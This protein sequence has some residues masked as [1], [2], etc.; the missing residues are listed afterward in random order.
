MGGASTISPESNNGGRRQ[1]RG[2]RATSITQIL[3]ISRK[4]CVLGK[5]SESTGGD[6]GMNASIAVL[7]SELAGLRNELA[8]LKQDG[9]RREDALG[10]MM[11]ALERQSVMIGR[12][13]IADPNSKGSSP[14]PSPEMGGAAKLWGHEMRAE[15]SPEESRRQLSSMDLEVASLLQCDGTLRQVLQK[16]KA[17]RLTFE[18]ATN[19]GGFQLSV[20]PDNRLRTAWT[21]VLGWLLVFTCCVLPLRIA[22]PILFSGTHEPFWNGLNIFIEWYFV[23]DVILNFFTGFRTREG[24]LDFRLSSI[25]KHYL[26]G[27]FLVDM[28]SSIPLD[29]ISHA[30]GVEVNIVL[31]LNKTLRVARLMRVMAIL[32]ANKS[33]RSY[34]DP[35]VMKLFQLIL[36]LLLAWHYVGCFWWALCTAFD[37]PIVER[38]RVLDPMMQCTDDT[39]LE[40]TL[41]PCDA[42]EV[43]DVPL[44][45]IGDCYLA[46]FYWAVFMSTG[47]NV[48][49]TP[50]LRGG[51]I[52]Y[53]CLVSFLGV[54]LHARRNRI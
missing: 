22:F 51:L 24:A 50:G 4:S 48:V 41:I 3:G 30:T 43:S 38:L 32:R 39:L 49:I 7:S 52:M 54:C 16:L 10:T 2:R 13:A 9:G 31:R 20:S 45:G 34:I 19:D 17:A 12:I 40:P 23:L 44:V 21:V 11:T 53:E 29:T 26:R 37:R 47:L 35:A 46:A 28:M 42:I 15:A 36:F 8:A 27:W 33:V 6:I 25:A 5:Q 14:T 1:S 18:R